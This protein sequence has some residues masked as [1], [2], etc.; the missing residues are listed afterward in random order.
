M[1]HSMWLAP[2]LGKPASPPE[3]LSFNKFGLSHQTIRNPHRHRR[4]RMIRSQ[5][6]SQIALPM[7]LVAACVFYSA[8]ARAQSAWPDVDCAKVDV[9]KLMTMDNMLAGH[10]LVQCGYMPGGHSAFGGATPAT[11]P[12]VRT[13]NRSCTSSMLCTKSEDMIAASTKDNGKTLVSNF[14]DD[15]GCCST[16]I[17]GTSYSTD[18]GK[19]FH[20]ILPPPFNDG[21]HGFNSGDP[22][23][24]F[25]S[26][27]N[28]FF[29]GDLAACSSGQGVGI[30]SSP[31]G[32]KWTS[33]S[34]AH[35]GSFDD[36]E[37]MW[38][39]NEPTSGTY[40]R[41]YVSWND[42]TTSCGA[43]GCL[44]VTYSDD[45]STWSTP[46]Q[47]GGTSSLFLRDVQ[48]T[49]TPAGTKRYEGKN[50]AV[51]IASMDEGGGGNATRQNYMFKSLDG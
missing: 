12:N 13:S 47:V 21:S 49:G 45:G 11:P 27:L 19:T 26:K 2:Q 39:D 6:I 37:S 24:V 14:N 35:N 36:R 9:A 51:F 44:F 18:G 29:A 17:S 22:I 38:V 20:E 28:K 4:T 40:G 43:G 30:W 32:K 33:E 23:V 41:M 1:V 42:Y 8:P 48:I 3:F 31:N 16:G 10:I 7:F 15:D 25:N 5:K 34:C 46:L 50:S